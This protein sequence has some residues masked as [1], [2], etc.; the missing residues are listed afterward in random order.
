M[1]I[2]RH[3][4]VV[5]DQQYLWE[6]AEQ[7]KWHQSP[8]PWD[9]FNVEAYPFYGE[10]D[11]HSLQSKRDVG[12]HRYCN[13]ARELPGTEST[14]G[15]LLPHRHFADA[16]VKDVLLEHLLTMTA[17]IDWEEDVSYFSLENDAT[18]SE[19]MDDW[20]GYLLSKPM[21]MEERH[22]FRLQQR[23]KSGVIGVLQQRLVCQPMPMPNNTFLIPSASTTTTGIAPPKVM[24]TQATAY[25][26]VHQI[27]RVSP[28]CLR[29]TDNGRVSRSSRR[30]GLPVRA[31]HG[32]IS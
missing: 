32:N 14:L 8:P 25:I 29:K 16:A 27:W 9:Y 26:L 3:G 23:R 4:Q 31:I 1:I 30:T 6:Y 12:A 2:I 20:V 5:F 18:A 7:H 13:C 24:P 21:T 19:A 17:G 22:V 11:L 28:G 10:T 15:E